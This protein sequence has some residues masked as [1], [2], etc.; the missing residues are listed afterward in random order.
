M[1]LFTELLVSAYLYLLLWLQ[2]LTGENEKQRELAGL[3]LV[4]VIAFSVLANVLIF[5]KTAFF[6]FRSYVL[7]L[8]RAKIYSLKKEKK[9]LDDVTATN[10]ITLKHD[11]TTIQIDNDQLKEVE[12]MHQH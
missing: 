2:Q 9:R 3:M 12:A 5:A 11:Q 6:K 10:N 1:S 7:K 8:E 4:G